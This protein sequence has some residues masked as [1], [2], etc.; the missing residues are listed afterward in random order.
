MCSS[1]HCI[2]DIASFDNADSMHRASSNK[3]DQFKP[4]FQVEGNTFRP[5]FFGYFIADWLLYNFAHGSFH[6]TKLCSRLYSIEIEFYPKKSDKL[7]FEPPFGG[8][9][10]N[11]HTPSIA[12]WKALLHFLSAIIGVFLY[13]LRLRHYKWNSV[14][15][16][17][18]QRGCVTLSAYFRGPGQYPQ[19][20]I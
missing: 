14:D 12:R 7:V 4:I 9:R 19:S 16:G 10:G 13:L 15:V 6:T 20:I 2:L 3:L 8:L 11:I 1:L 17:V 5:I 18:F